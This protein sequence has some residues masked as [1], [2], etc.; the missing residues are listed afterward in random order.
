MKD[1][2]VLVKRSIEKDVDPK[3]KG[4]DYDTNFGNTYFSLHGEWVWSGT[5]VAPEWWIEEVPLSSL[6]ESIM[7]TENQRQQ[8][9]IQLLNMGL[10]AYACMLKYDEWLK[11]KLT[12]KP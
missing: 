2:T 11:N 5:K 1:Q 7:P 4:K 3:I 6:I 12:S 10:N 9:R 8:K